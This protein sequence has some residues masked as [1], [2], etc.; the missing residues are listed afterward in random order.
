MQD[1][2]KYLN[3][4]KVVSGRLFRELAVNFYLFFFY[5]WFSIC[6]LFPQK[7]KTVFMTY[8]GYNALHTVEAMEK[9][10]SE[11]CI[12]GVTKHCHVTFEPKNNR[13]IFKLSGFRWLNWL[14]FIY[15]LATAKRVIVDNYYGFLAVTNFKKNTTCVQLWHAAG[16]VKK[17]GLTDLS[18]QH[19][20]E[21][22]VKRFK[23][24]YNRFDHVVV[25]S[26]NMVPIFGESFGLPAE[27]MLR[28][29]IPRTDFFF[30]EKKKD[31]VTNEL[32]RTYPLLK[33]KK[34]ILY[35]PTFRDEEMKIETF[36]LDIEDMYKQLRDE[37]VL[38][39]KTHPL[40]HHKIENKYGDFVL[41]MSQHENINH[42]L[43]ATDILISDY[44]SVPFEF[45]LLERP[46]LFYAYDRETYLKDRGVWGDYEAFVP[47]P[48]VQSTKEIVALIQ[49]NQFDMKKIQQFNKEWNQYSN[50]NAS[51]NLAQFLYK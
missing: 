32:F 38:V 4:S 51:H 49:A 33:E 6:K 48:V 30:D 19:R 25:G 16:A 21:Q 37:Y 31:T 28:T 35:A 3:E 22:A 26:E 41:D 11:Q 40:V 34:V 18:V 10:R 42:L 36:R 44:S 45:A 24:V 23:K 29:G 1:N 14:C 20:S 2:I 39:I 15:H 47:G 50:G 5:A 9:L 8:F 17:F 43:L 7:E 46:M 27:K 13:T 12:I